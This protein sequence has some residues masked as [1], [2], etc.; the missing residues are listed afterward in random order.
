[1]S[2]DDP[3]FI[4]FVL[5]LPALCGIVLIAEGIKRLRKD[6][7]AGLI[8]VITGFLFLALTVLFYFFFSTYLGRR[9]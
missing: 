7:Q 4:Y 3:Q 8:G 1:M 5:A 9:V 6:E 2:P